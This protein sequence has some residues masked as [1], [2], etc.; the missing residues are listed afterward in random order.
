MSYTAYYS[1]AR[2]ADLCS[3]TEVVSSEVGLFPSI[4]AIPAARVQ[5]SSSFISELHYT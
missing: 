4:R 5:K 3:H 2:D 1:A